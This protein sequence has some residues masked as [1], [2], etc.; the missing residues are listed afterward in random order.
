[1]GTQ[2][3]SSDE[4]VRGWY[5]DQLRL[6]LDYLRLIRTRGYDVDEREIDTL[7]A[8]I[9]SPEVE[10]EIGPKSVSDLQ[11]RLALLDLLEEGDD[12]AIKLLLLRLKAIT[13][14]MKPDKNHPR[15]H[16][17][18]E[19]KREFSASY[20]VDSL[21]RLAGTMPRKYEE[22]VLEWASEHKRDLFLTWE[23]YAQVRMYA[24]L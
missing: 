1:M 3:Q 24:N 7:E 9:G 2:E 16:F 13:V 10:G 18:I 5:L 14:R 21:E 19:Y 15:P 23:N 11:R 22:L 8:E 17:H 6:R 12:R 20:A 4:E